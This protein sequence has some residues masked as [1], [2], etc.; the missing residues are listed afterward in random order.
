MGPVSD[1]PP[2]KLFSQSPPDNCPAVAGLGIQTSVGL[3]QPSSSVGGG[4]GV[5]VSTTV[6]HSSGVTH[7]ITRPVDS[8]V[9]TV[10]PPFSHRSEFCW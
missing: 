1:A 3:A 9:S 6:T 10:F 2:A 8:V 4:G 5:S 7:T